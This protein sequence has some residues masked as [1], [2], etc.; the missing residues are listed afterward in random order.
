[1]SNISQILAFIGFGGF[2]AIGGI[3]FRLAWKLASITLQTE[4]NR[5]D[6]CKLDSKQDET[7]TAI[8]KIEKQNERILTILEERENVRRKLTQK[9]D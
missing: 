1:M 2:I 9:K 3:V 8:S 4:I 6:I 7:F 5:Q